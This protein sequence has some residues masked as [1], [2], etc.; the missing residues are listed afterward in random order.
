MNLEQLKQIS[1]ARALQ[2]MVD[3]GHFSIC[4]IDNLAKQAGVIIPQEAYQ[5]MRNYHCVNFNK[6]TTDERQILL[7][8]CGQAL[9]QGRVDVMKE[10]FGAHLQNEGLLPEGQKL[11]GA[12][13]NFYS[14]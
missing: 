8:L 11:T 5:I 7:S 4:T 10:V 6:M 12:L 13:V 14:E 9:A 3:K 1:V 2:E